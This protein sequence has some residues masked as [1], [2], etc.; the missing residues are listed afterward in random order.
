ME[1]G[2][3]QAYSHCAWDRKKDTPER[4]VFCIVW[5]S[6]VWGNLSPGRQGIDGTQTTRE[7]KCAEGVE[8]T[9]WVGTEHEQIW[10]AGLALI[11]HLC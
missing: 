2:G 10:R 7:V 5:T 1:G 3:E 4:T 6:Y 8:G 11:V 9:I